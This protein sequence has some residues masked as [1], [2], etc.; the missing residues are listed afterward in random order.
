MRQREERFLKAGA[1]DFET[2]EACIAGEQFA[3]DRFRFGGMNLH[4]IA[5][6]MN[7]A[8]TGKA[9]KSIRA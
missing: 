3:H 6:F 9:T 4:R 8:H 1:A 7:F 5:I 2:R